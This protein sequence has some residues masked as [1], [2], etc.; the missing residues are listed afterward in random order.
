M[1]PKLENKH[2]HALYLARAD[3]K[4]FNHKGIFMFLDGLVACYAIN[5]TATFTSQKDKDSFRA[6]ESVHY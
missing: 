5:D 3:S 1:I 4:K 6:G 2:E